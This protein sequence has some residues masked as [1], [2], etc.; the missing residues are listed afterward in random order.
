L[1]VG[2]ADEAAGLGFVDGHFWDEGDAH[3]CADHGEEAGEVA[4]FEDD[5]RI[6]AGTVAGGYGSFAEAV[7]VAEEE[8]GIAAEIGELQFGAACELVRFG[9]RGVEAFGE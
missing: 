1:W 9:E 2:D 4:A 7:A 8:E 5:V 3:A 6:E